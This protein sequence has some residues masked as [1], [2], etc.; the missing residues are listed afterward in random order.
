MV[1]L[2]EP[3]NETMNRDLGSRV[4]AEETD[5]PES[6]VLHS[7]EVANDVIASLMQGAQPSMRFQGSTPEEL[8]TWKGDFEPQ[9][10]QLLGDSAPPQDWQ[11]TIEERVEFDDHTRCQLLVT[12]D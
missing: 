1:A 2:A 12:S 11:I 3:H 5:P 7:P 10:H 6:T 9:L 8:H 4:T